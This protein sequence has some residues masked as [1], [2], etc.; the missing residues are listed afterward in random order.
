MGGVKAGRRERIIAFPQDD[1]LA[2]RFVLE[3]FL[4]VLIPTPRPVS[5]SKDENSKTD[6]ARSVLGAPKQIATFFEFFVLGKELEA[7]SSKK[8]KS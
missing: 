5:I 6:R 1:F 7:W 2:N 3:R 8:L 4:Q